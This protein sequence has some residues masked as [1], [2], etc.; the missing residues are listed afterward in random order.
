M[1]RISYLSITIIRDVIVLFG[2]C[3]GRKISSF[4]TIEDFD[5]VRK[6]KKEKG[7]RNFGAPKKT[8]KTKPVKAQRVIKRAPKVQM[9]PGPKAVKISQIMA[10]PKELEQDVR[11]SLSKFI[12]L[13]GVCSRRRATEMVAAGLVNINGEIIRE[14]GF[15]VGDKDIVK[16]E[17]RLV[18]QEEKVY[19]LL[20]KPKDYITTV[21][22]DKNRKIV[23]D[24]IQLSTK[25]RLYPVGRLDR[26]TTGLLILTNDGELAL[27]LSHPRY[28]MSK[29]Y[30]ATLQKPLAQSAMNK[31]VHEGVYLEDELQD[32]LVRV[33]AMCYVKG[34]TRKEVMVET[35][36]G[37]YRVI[38]RMFEALGY[39]V[40]KL[41]RIE[42]AGLNKNGIRV[43]Q[44][45]HL[46]QNEVNALKNMG[47]K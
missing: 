30:H 7:R 39:D 17:G 2:G 1:Y 46:Q 8:S 20:N 22:D 32:G 29:T 6:S 43:S 44:W 38:R 21:S 47:N 14:P 23:M 40:K 26:A 12:A 36:S 42:Y 31:M 18:T 16:V 45:R 25:S 9:T 28:E 27:K 13:A 37:K 11:P 24:L 3:M 15:R 41:D 10:S 35:H 4:K 19:I 5:A 33:D 34:G